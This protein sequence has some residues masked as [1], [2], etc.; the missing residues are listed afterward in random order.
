MLNALE[1]D[2]HEAGKLQ[3]QQLIG[4]V[5]ILV[6]HYY[7]NFVQPL[8]FQAVTGPV[9]LATH[10]LSKIHVWG[11]SATGKLERPFK[12]DNPFAYVPFRQCDT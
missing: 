12:A 2:Q 8:F 5:I 11:Q 1:Y 3:T 4:L 9:N 10:Q 6:M 7:W